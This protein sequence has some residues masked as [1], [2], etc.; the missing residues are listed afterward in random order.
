VTEF[1]NDESLKAVCEEV[2]KTEFS[3]DRLVTILDFLSAEAENMAAQA[4][5]DSDSY[6]REAQ[7]SKDRELIDLSVFYAQKSCEAQ[8]VA[9]TLKMA[10]AYA[11]D[12]C[13][14]LSSVNYW[15]E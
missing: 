5:S 14:G 12:Y 7:I 6:L 4:E 15:R 13:S 9:K 1:F 11:I 8:N 10:L 3:Y 2:S